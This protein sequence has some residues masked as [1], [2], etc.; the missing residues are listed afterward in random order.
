MSLLELTIGWISPPQCVGC[1][2][3]GSVLCNDCT[4]A[5]VVQ[6]GERCGYCS[7]LSS[8]SKTCSNCLKKGLPS[9]IWITT[10]YDGLISEL[11]RNYKFDHQRHIAD[12][13]AKQMA[14]TYLQIAPKQT[15]E[16][17]IVPVPTATKRVRERGFDHAVLL[18]EEIA[19]ELNL[20]CARLLGRLGQVSQV[21][22]HRNLR[23]TQ[24]DGVYYTRHSSQL[25]GKSIMLVDDVMTTGATLISAT[26]ALKTAGALKVDALVFAMRPKK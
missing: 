9:H 5:N 21:G 19:Q 14:G 13:L 26:K 2:D 7:V 25:K 12:E 23:L 4:E 8:K 15:Q 16:Q 10:T 3:E 6:F 11:V 1:S 20:P 18:A 17:L 22:R 24:L